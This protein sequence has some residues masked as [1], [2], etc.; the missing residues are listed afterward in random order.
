MHFFELTNCCM[1]VCEL[2]CVQ[3]LKK[4]ASMQAEHVKA[5][6]CQIFIMSICMLTVKHIKHEWHTESL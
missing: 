1:C 6:P 2:T 3:H 4:S 5:A